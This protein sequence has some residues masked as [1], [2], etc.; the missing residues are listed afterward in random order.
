MG[1]ANR[2]LKDQLQLHDSQVSIILVDCLDVLSE[3]TASHGLEIGGFSIY[4]PVY[5]FSNKKVT[6]LRLS[7]A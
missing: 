5:L 2:K 1:D 4:P 3:R 6:H 7:T